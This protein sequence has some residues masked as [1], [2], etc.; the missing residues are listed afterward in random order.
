MN[1]EAFLL[2]ITNLSEETHAFFESQL[3][4]INIPSKDIDAFRRLIHEVEH[5]PVSQVIFVSSTSV[6]AE[7]NQTV[8]ESQSDE[9]PGGTLYE[10]ENLFVENTHF[11]T[12][13]LRFGGLIG[14]S[15]HPGRFFR[16][17]RPVRNPDAPVNLIHRDDCI[18]IISSVIEQECWGETFNC[19]ADTHPTKRAFYTHA[20]KSIG[21]DIPVFSETEES[22]FKIISNKKVKKRLNY[23]FIHPDLMQIDF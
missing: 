2:D 11:E 14:H 20:A 4:I 3:L 12:T 9:L 6:Y 13:V 8:T 19:C 10:I 17:G 18:G 16:H 22:T 15:R 5:S 21:E 23:T 1:I 7:H